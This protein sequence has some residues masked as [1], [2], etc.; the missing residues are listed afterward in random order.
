MCVFQFCPG[1]SS[2]TCT[3]GSSTTEVRPSLSD[4][5]LLA[6]EDFGL[7]SLEAAGL[8]CDNPAIASPACGFCNVEYVGDKFVVVENGFIYE[9]FVSAENGARRM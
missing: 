3:S 7:S 1:L 5:G 2:C 4:E 6:A 8:N 9:V